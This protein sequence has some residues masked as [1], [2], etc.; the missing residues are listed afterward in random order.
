VEADKLLER[1]AGLA[2][3]PQAIG[4]AGIKAQALRDGLAYWSARRRGG[5]LPA[6]ADLDPTDIPRLLPHVELSEVVDGGRDFRFRLVGSHL[7]DTDGVNPTGALLSGFFRNTTY[8]AYQFGLY[9]WVVAHR[10]PL[11]SGSRVPLLSRG[12]G[13]AVLTERLYLPL[14]SDGETVDMILNFQVCEG[15]AHAQLQLENALDP[16][17]GES[18]LYAI[19][20]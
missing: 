9:R 13:L 3:P 5:R 20:A 8:T 18:F 6:R 19:Q 10:A 14:A 1:D 16:K 17:H 2:G 4:P 12:G 15:M 11:Y 7:V